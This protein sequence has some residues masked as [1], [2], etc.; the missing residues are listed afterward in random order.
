[1]TFIAKGSYV[2]AAL[3]MLA[4]PNSSIAARVNEA[5]PTLTQDSTLGPLHLFMTL[6]QVQSV[7]GKGHLTGYPPASYAKNGHCILEYTDGTSR[8][9]IRIMGD[10]DVFDIRV[11]LNSANTE[12]LPHIP[13][14][15][16]PLSKWKWVGKPI[17]YPASRRHVPGLNTTS[18]PGGTEKDSF[19][20]SKSVKVHFTE[21]HEHTIDVE[22][23]HEI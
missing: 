20:N 6:G 5:P 10:Y 15:L 9:S 18:E 4:S 13:A 11:T 3:L 8:L 16:G 23:G 7:L 2:A 14:S 12:R 19:I 17:S 22:I 21:T 1:M